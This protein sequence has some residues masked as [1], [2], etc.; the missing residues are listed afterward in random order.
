MTDRAKTARN[1]RRKFLKGAAVAGAAV[2]TPAVVPAF[3]LLEAVS[4]GTLDGGHGVLVY[5]YGKQT[6]LWGLW[7][8]PE[9]FLRFTVS[10]PV[11]AIE[12][13]RPQVIATATN[14]L[15]LLR[16]RVRGQAMKLAHHLSVV[17]VEDEVV[18]RE[19]ALPDL[20]DML[21]KSYR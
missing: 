5:H 19:R 3:S 6:A 15:E 14:R 13:P 16:R 2:A 8:L 12:L 20:Q 4:K 9:Q 10:K 7:A 1:T 21:P 18:V 17:V 11:L